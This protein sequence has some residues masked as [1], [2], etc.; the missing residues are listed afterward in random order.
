MSEQ[1]EF[2]CALSDEQRRAPMQSIGARRGALC[3]VR[4]F[5]QANKRDSHNSAKHRA[6]ST[7][8]NAWGDGQVRY[9]KAAVQARL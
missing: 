9:K 1:S 6:N 2:G 4:L 8:T 3:F 5:G 7:Q